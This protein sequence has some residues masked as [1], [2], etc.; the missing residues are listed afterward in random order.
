VG[1][2]WILEDQGAKNGTWVGNRRVTRHRLLD[3][4]VV[5]VGHTVVVFRDRGGEA[6]DVETLAPGAQPGLD[7]LSVELAG[8]LAELAKASREVVS[9]RGV[10]H[11][12]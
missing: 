7:T 11:E 10:G 9:N 2:T 12:G 4:D 1:T 6:D 5:L 8:T 3:R